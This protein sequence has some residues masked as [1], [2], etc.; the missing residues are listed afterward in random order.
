[1]K[2][3]YSTGQTRGWVEMDVMPERKVLSYS[4]AG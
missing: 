3:N 1:V 2:V 4:A